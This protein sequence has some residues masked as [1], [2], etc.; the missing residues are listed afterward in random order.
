MAGS[1]ED[2]QVCRGDVQSAKSVTVRT[3]P[4]A[5]LCS[6]AMPRASRADRTG[7]RLLAVAAVMVVL[8][9]ASYALWDRPVA[10]WAFHR[11]L[12][13]QR[14][15]RR[16][17]ALGEGVY[18]IVLVFVI[19]LA[20]A[21]R[22]KHAVTLRAAKSAVA[23]AAAG[24]AANALKVV[25]GRAR[26]RALDDGVWGFHFFELGYRFNS[27]PSGHAAIAAAVAAS[28]CL[29]RPGAWPLAVALWLALAS[30]RVLTG[31]H[32]VGDVLAGGAIGI[33]V[34]VLVDR[35]SWLS[36]VLRRRIPEREELVT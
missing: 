31:S 19:G 25:F 16:L 2:R 10:D 32:F 22:R 15:A 9:A 23:I 33:V 11:P 6:G 35:W 13:W 12:A 4:V 24:L 17:S 30:G 5:L 3:A 26:P 20:A 18:W 29:A 1:E 7:D 21:I 36:Q 8:A 27:F 14:A 28:L 34:M